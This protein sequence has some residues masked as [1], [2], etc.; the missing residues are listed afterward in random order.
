[1]KAVSLVITLV[2]CPGLFLAGC[3]KAS[4]GAAESSSGPSDSRA[5]RSAGNG[6][7]GGLLTKEEVGAVI[8]QPVTSVEGRG[9]HLTY[10][11]DVMLL[12]ATIE[13]DRKRD[14]A[15]AIQA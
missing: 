5:S 14:V 9:T 12:E 4:P 1:M 6:A 11:T 2:L 7:A 13:L 8:G 10:K 3:N 15:D